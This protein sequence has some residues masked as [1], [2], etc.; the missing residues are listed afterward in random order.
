MQFVQKSG[1]SKEGNDG[2]VA[3]PKYPGDRFSI[4]EDV[5]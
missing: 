2:L 5:L 3:R 1:S 4:D